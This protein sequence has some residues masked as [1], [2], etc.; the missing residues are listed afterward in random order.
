MPS[1]TKHW[2]AGDLCLITVETLR[3]LALLHLGTTGVFPAQRSLTSLKQVC[4]KSALWV[5]ALW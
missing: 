5:S 4:I 2:G 3:D 1:Q